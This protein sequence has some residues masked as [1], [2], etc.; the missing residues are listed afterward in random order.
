LEKHHGLNPYEAS[1]RL[2]KIKQRAGL[3][4]A[5]NAI[6]GRTG[7]VYDPRNGEHVGNLLTER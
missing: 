1:E 6:F 4:A 2:H 5:D 7:D 3:G